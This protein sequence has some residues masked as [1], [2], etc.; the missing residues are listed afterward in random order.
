M[1]EYLILHKSKNLKIDRSFLSR[2]FP[3]HRIIYPALVK[4]AR[5]EIEI[6]IRL[7]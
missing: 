7:T 3:N 1:S 6:I 2:I 4:L 5:E